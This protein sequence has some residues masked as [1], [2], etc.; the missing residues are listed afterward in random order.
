MRGSKDKRPPEWQ[1]LTP[2]F[3]Q[4]GASPVPA[5]CS[6]WEPLQITFHVIDEDLGDLSERL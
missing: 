3:P 4:D 1:E 2:T 5:V 6:L